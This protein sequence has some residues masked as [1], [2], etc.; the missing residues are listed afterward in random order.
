MDGGRLIFLAE[1]SG[2]LVFYYFFDRW[3]NIL[4]SPDL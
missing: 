2:T 4:D 3:P 1:I